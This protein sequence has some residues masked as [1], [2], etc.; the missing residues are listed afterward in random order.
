MMPPDHDHACL[1]RAVPC[2]CGRYTHSLLLAC[3]EQLASLGEG[4][5]LAERAHRYESLRRQT[6]EARVVELEAELGEARESLAAVRGSR[7]STQTD[8]ITIT[9]VHGTA[10]D[11]ERSDSHGGGC[12]EAELKQW[13]EKIQAARGAEKA[14]MQLE[15]EQNARRMSTLSVELKLAREHIEQCEEKERMSMSM[16]T[17]QDMQGFIAGV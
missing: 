15:R 10:N 1:C 11:N 4:K 16:T 12:S 3:R 6:A 17:M 5:A 8:E 2:L 14:A 9:E 13:V 7:A